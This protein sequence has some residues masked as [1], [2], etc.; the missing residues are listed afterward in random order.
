MLFRGE[1]KGAK[2]NSSTQPGYRRFSGRGDLLD[3][4][5]LQQEEAPTVLL[6]NEPR[7]LSLARGRRPISRLALL[8][9]SSRF[10]NSKT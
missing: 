6:E 5:L 1:E 4:R 8:C 10:F 3:Q 9:R 2:E 7:A